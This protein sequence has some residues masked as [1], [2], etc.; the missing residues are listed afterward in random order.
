M[1]ENLPDEI[2][3]ELLSKL[4][5]GISQQPHLELTNMKI[6]TEYFPSNREIRFD[7]ADRNPMIPES[8]WLPRSVANLTLDDAVILRDKLNEFLLEA[9]LEQG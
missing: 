7:V 4:K 1:L 9:Q 2:K 8:D 3:K 6:Y 5:E